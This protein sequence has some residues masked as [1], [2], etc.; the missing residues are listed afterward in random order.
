VGGGTSLFQTGRSKNLEEI[1]R[2]FLDEH[3]S[4][5]PAELNCL[6]DT[7]KDETVKIFTRADLRRKIEKVRNDEKSCRERH[8]SMEKDIGCLKRKQS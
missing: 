8:D 3:T 5:G 2:E 1:K 4:V 7:V 6:I